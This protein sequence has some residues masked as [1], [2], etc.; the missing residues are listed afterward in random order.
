MTKQFRRPK[1]RTDCILRNLSDKGFSVTPWVSAV[2][3]TNEEKAKLPLLSVD[4]KIYLI[5]KESEDA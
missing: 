1:T 3:L 2:K 5:A 4:G